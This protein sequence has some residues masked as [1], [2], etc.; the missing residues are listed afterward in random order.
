[1]GKYT[2]VFIDPAFIIIIIIQS[3]IM[4]TRMGILNFLL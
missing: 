2:L 1:M 3:V 4:E